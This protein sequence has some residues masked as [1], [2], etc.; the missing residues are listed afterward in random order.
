MRQLL[1]TNKNFRLFWMAISISSLG[2]YV[3]DIAFAQLVYLVTKSTLLTSYVFAIK[4]VFTFLS[5]FTATYVD[6]HNKKKILIGTSAGQGIVLVFLLFL[7]QNQMLNSYILIGFVTIQTV[8]STFG[9]P[10]QN[11]FLSCVVT[12]EEMLSARSSLHMFMNFIQIFSYTCAGALITF[13]G[14]PGAILLDAFTFLLAVILMC[15][16][17][18]KEGENQKF[19]STQEFFENVREG[20]HFVLH[21]KLI[22]SVLIV[23]FFGNLLIAPVEG[24]MPAYLAQGGYGDYAYASFMIGIALGGI[25]GAWL[26]TKVQDKL[27]KGKLFACGFFLGAL[28]LG[29]LYLNHIVMVYISALFLGASCSFVSVLNATILQMNTP[30]E[31]MARIFSIF[32]CISCVAS[33]LGIVAAGALGEVLDMAVVFM[34]LALPL[35]LNA[36]LTRKVIRT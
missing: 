10:A 36:L 4:I 12:K 30:K 26:L 6:R 5:V 31:M 2:D 15:L 14:I 21:E 8:F 20:F 34:I 27:E 35:L 24:L 29:M 1:K 11:A 32:K 25:G 3:D 33:P 9:T 22:Y 28:G 16:T 18:N 7:Y 19:H 23:T 13:I 17:E